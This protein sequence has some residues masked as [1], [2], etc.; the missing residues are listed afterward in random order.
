MKS[1]VA[2]FR[3]F[4]IFRYTLLLFYKNTFTWQI[5]IMFLPHPQLLQD[6]PDLPTCPTV[7]LLSLKKERKNPQT[8]KKH[9]NTK[10][11]SK[12]ISKR[13]IRQNKVKQNKNETKRSQK[14]SWAHF[15]VA[16]LL[17]DMGSCP[18]M[19]LIYPI[20]LHWGKL[21]VLVVYVMF[22]FSNLMLITL[23]FYL[24]VNLAK[25]LSVL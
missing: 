13:Q 16:Q 14:Y 23:V 1:Y 5:L 17:L 11:K 8:W 18:G 25:G 19:S 9:Q 15:F 10:M 24:L 6:P 12:Q 2:S 20:R 21:G 7:C 4:P 3:N 22:Q